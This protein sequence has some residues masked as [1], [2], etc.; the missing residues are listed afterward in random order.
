MIEK[1]FS[2]W[3]NLKKRFYSTIEKQIVEIKEK[4]YKVALGCALGIGINFIPTLGIGFIF[5]F[6]LAVLFRVNQ[7]SAAVTSLL[8]GPLVPLMY[9]LNFVIGGLILSP[10]TGKD[11]LLEFIISQYSMILKLGHFQDKVF[12]FLELFGFTF[13]LGAAVNAALF[14]IASYFFVTFL[15]NKISMEVHKN[16]RT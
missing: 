5:A 11:S 16:K 12:N 1:R 8:T 2:R 15:L 13:L 9:A 10:V 3:E 4:P 6:V 14:G 7:A